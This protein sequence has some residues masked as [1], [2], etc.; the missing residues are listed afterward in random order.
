MILAACSPFLKGDWNRPVTRSRATIS[1]A[2]YIF[3]PLAGNI[4][5]KLHSDDD[6]ARA[7][8]ESRIFYSPRNPFARECIIARCDL[9]AGD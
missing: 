2:H 5:T 1:D 8:R 4:A 6:D 3:D 9:T 7:S